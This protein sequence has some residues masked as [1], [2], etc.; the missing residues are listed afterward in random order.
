MIFRLLFD[1]KVLT[2]SSFY[3]VYSVSLIR[4][5]KT[6]YGVIISEVGFI[7]MLEILQK[8]I[9]SNAQ[10]VEIPMY[11]KSQNRIG[12]SKMKVFKTMKAYMRFLIKKNKEML[13]TYTSDR[14]VKSGR[15]R[16]LYTQKKKS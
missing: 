2:L 8:A 6:K 5:I 13:E 12:K 14:V 9:S 4:K 15:Q 11:L 1:I 7:S 10:I 3:R 16:A